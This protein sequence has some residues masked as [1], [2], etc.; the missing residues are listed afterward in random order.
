MATR[1][2][3]VAKVS[4]RVKRPNTYTRK[5]GQTSGASPAQWTAALTMHFFL[6]PSLPNR[7]LFLPDHA[8]PRSGYLNRLFDT[9]TAAQPLATP[10]AFEGGRRTR[11]R[12]ISRKS[13]GE[14]WMRALAS[15]KGR[16]TADLV[17]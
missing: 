9:T 1:G 7:P 16:I 2:Y 14:R 4:D 17:G 10:N 15:C 12:G 5:Q 3:G 8:E 6:A 13:R 11:L